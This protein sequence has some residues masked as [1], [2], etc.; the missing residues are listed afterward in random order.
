VNELSW[1]RPVTRSV[2]GAPIGNGRMGTLVWTTPETVELQ[3]NRV[4]VFGV[5]RNAA[6]AHFPG[7]TDYGG[8]CGRVTIHFGGEVVG[9]GSDFRQRLSLSDARCEVSGAGVRAECWIAAVAVGALGAGAGASEERARALRLDAEGGTRV[10][11][12][13]AAVS[14]DPGAPAGPAAEAIL[15]A[16][17]APGAVGELAREHAAWWGGF[18]GR[19]VVEVT[20]GGGVGERAARDRELYLYHMAATSRGAYPPKWNGSVFVTEGD[21]RDWG[22][23]Y[24]LWTTEM[25]TWRLL[26]SDA[27][28]L[29]GPFFGMYRRQLPALER[30]AR[31][32]WGADGIFLPETTPFDGPAVSPSLTERC[33]YDYHLST[34]IS[35]TAHSNGGYSWISHVASSAAELAVH[36]WWRYRTTGDL[37]WLRSCAYPFLRGVAEFYASIAREGEDGLFHIQGTNAHE[38]FWGVTD[39]VMDLAAIRG[40]VPL[41]FRASELLELDAASRRRWR[42][43]LDRLAPYPMGSDPRALPAGVLAEDAWGGGL[44]GSVDGSRNPEDV[45]LAPVFPFEDCTLETREPGL[46]AAARRTLDLAGR[47]GR[48]LAGEA[49]NTAIRSPIAAV[50]MG[51]SRDLPA[52]LSRYRSAF[53][54]L[55]NGFSLF[56]QVTPGYQ[57][58]SI[59]HLGLGA[60]VLQE[61]LFQSVAGRPGEREVIRVFPAWPDAWDARFRLLARGGFM[62]S[63][64][65]R[66]GEVG[67]IEIESR[68][69]EECRVRL[70]WP[71]GCRARAV[72][73]AGSVAAAVAGGIVSFATSAGGRYRLTPARSP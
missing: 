6:G 38:D 30:A 51:S 54:P 45:Q 21:A 47:H 49:L 29:A 18:W 73:G 5:N 1:D 15:G 32:R 12:A 48:V 71:E 22:A 24:W 28:D 40:T 70:P 3:I 19:T 31:Q 10:I 53:A 36:A 72:D 66:G 64:S 50:R 65:V 46:L 35:E 25:L 58:H 67:P 60:M 42:D 39:S 4:D 16:A 13:A 52:I 17:S 62:V 33:G 69:G 26:A 27:A 57:A 44:R 59:K 63:A 56:E 61:A 34:L 23:Q 37:S 41:A 20:N 2:E 11:L 55:D 68:L 8:G 14:W 43:L 9:A 7:T